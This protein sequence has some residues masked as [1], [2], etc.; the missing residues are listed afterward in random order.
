MSKFIMTL[1]QDWANDYLMKFTYDLL[2][3]YDINATIFY[4][5][6]EFDIPKNVDIGL[7][8]NFTKGINSLESTFEELY[9][10]Y[11]N[12]ST[13]RSHALYNNEYLRDVYYKF[14]ITKQSNY[15]MLFQDDIKSVKVS[16]ITNEYPLYFMDM[17]YLHIFDKVNS[18]DY[19]DA[20][21]KQSKSGLKIFDFHPIHLFLN[22]PS[23]EY[24]KSCKK[25]YHET[26]KL[27]E[28]INKTEYGVLD[29]FK[30]L[31]LNYKFK[32]VFSNL[33]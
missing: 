5:N 27:K 14:N 11:E 15:M 1:D 30:D 17:Y 10:C 26:K 24:Y 4:T 28:Y 9:E 23:T 8:P 19:I 21:I 6:K 2:F 18:F 12:I 29:L 13:I 25:Y 31:A 16:K 22:T 20:S 7:H 33:D 32:T 3:E